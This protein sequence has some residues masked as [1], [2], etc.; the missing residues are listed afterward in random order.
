MTGEPSRLQIVWQAIRPATLWAAIVPVALGTALA[1]SQG[2][3][4]PEAAMAAL[5]GAIFIQIG[6]N[7]VNDYADFKRGADTAT[8]LGPARV[9]QKGW[10]SPEQV[11]R[12]A[13]IAFVAAVVCGLFLVGIAGWPVVII[14][15][16]S[17]LCGVGYTSGPWP[18]AYVGVGD[19]FVFL[20]FGVVAVCGT[21]FVQTHTLTW[22]CLLASMA[23]GC[24]STAI[25]VVNN[26]RDRF[27]DAPAG[28]KTLAVRFGARFVRM[29]YAILVLGAYGLLLAAWAFGLG[30]VGWLLPL[31]SLPL[32]I[33]A[34]RA[35]H[36]MDGAALN[37][38]LG[39]TA[40]LE[41]FFGGLL[42]VGVLL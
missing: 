32:A 42:A 30:N 2:A 40:R 24:W 23:L 9:T 13:V 14:G 3:R 10:V 19:F 17:I 31:L 16:L 38:W 36:N 8:R 22:S 37:P 26:L 18:F 5:L 11:K 25:L 15:V 34:V 39:N 21:F 4:V 28:K 41:L 12:G 6:T 33:R 7:L 1:Y 29:E 35:I 20:F 27:T